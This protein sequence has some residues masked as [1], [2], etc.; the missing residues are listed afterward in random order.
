MPCSSK[1]AALEF[2]RLEFARYGSVLL[3]KREYNNGNLMELT[4]ETTILHTP[5]KIGVSVYRTTLDP[6]LV[7]EAN[8]P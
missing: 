8:Q 3:S 7:K 6:H 5:K 2:I 4:Y 1:E